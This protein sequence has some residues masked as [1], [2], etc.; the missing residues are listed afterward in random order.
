MASDKN[1][2]K[3]F[4]VVNPLSAAGRTGRKW[5]RIHAAIE[6]ELGKTDYKLT[7]R[8]NQAAELV[9]EALEA[10]YDYIISVGGDGFNSIQ[11]PC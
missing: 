11:L 2:T 7:T 8:A 1:R 9:R 6:R 4:A 3:P 10:G 5:P